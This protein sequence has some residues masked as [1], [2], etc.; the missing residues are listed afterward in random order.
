MEQEIWKPIKGFEGYEISNLGRVYSQYSGKILSPALNYN[1]TSGY[2]RVSIKGNDGKYHTKLL[3]RALAEAFIP[4][5]DPI[6]KTYINHKDGNKLN[7]SLDNLE[8]VSPI[9][10]VRHAWK[11][12]LGNVQ[13]KANVNLEKAR[14]SIRK[15]NK[16]SDIIKAMNTA[17]KI[18]EGY[19]LIVMKHK[20]FLSTLTFDS[21]LLAANTLKTTTENVAHSISENKCI[22][23]YIVYGF[24]NKDLQKFANGEPLPDMLKAIPWEKF[25][26]E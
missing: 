26:I 20:K 5:D 10:N 17:N 18:M 25:I 19:V 11:N 8:W 14:E 22:N 2:W 6:H 23:G 3:H 24:K 13:E 12:N 9:E 15:G 21:T 4:N 7:I 16:Y 1:D